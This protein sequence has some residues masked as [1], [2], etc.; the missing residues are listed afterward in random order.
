MARKRITDEN[1][2]VLFQNDGEDESGSCSENEL[3][4]SSDD[5]GVNDIYFPIQELIT[6]V[7]RVRGTPTAIMVLLT[8]GSLT[9]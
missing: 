5:D 7:A 6:I 3:Y 9:Y 4:I 2:R 8:T 1:I